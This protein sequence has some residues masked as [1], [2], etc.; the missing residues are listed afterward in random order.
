MPFTV[1]PDGHAQADGRRYVTEVHSDGVGEF[2]R[3]EYL[4]AVGADTNAIATAR[5]AVLLVSAADNEAEQAIEAD[6]MPALRFQ[7]AT[8]FVARVREF[9]R[10]RDKEALALVAV[11]LRNR[12]AA[13]D[14][15][16]T[17][18]QNAFGFTTP[19]W[20][21]FK[22]KMQSLANAYDEVNAAVG[23]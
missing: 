4:A 18:V 17:Q 6:A 22:T 1:T 10:D 20:N 3:L 7:N 2:A 9:Y 5:N 14:L 11:W 21:T 13:G 15:T 16:E 19:Q 23:E 12:I 8:Q